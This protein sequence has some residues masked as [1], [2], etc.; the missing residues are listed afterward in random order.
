MSKFRRT[1]RSKT[2]ISTASLPDIVFMMLFFFMVTATIRTDDK[3]VKT[4]VP[5]ARELTKIEKETL[6]KEIRVGVPINAE[7]GTEPKLAVDSRWI[8]MNE[9]PQWVNQKRDELPEHYKDQMI[10][11]LKA[12]EMV[13]MGMVADIQEELKRSNAR[14]ILYRTLDKVD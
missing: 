9:L 2:E 13:D 6:L 3:L 12:D 11:V 10:I 4:E 7:L 8:S 1:T 5:Q 14:K